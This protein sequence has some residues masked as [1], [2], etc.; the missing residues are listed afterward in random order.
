MEDI[1]KKVAELN[2]AVNKLI[3]DVQ[4]EHTAMEKNLVSKSSF[5]EYS[6]NAKRSLEEIYDKLAK[7]Q[8]PVVN[9]IEEDK[10]D[11]ETKQQVFAEWL[12]KGVLGPEERKV[13][14]IAD[15]THAGVLA[16]YEYVNEIIRKATLFSPLR[17]IANIRQT[18][19]YAVELPSETGIGVATWVAESGEKT[20]TTGLEYALTEINTFEMKILYKATQKMLEDSR[21][22]IESEI[23]QASG[24]GFGLL[25]GTAFYSG[26][27]TTSPEGIVVNATVLADARNVATDNTLVF[28]D[29]IG[30]S[31]QLASPYIPNAAWLLNRGT[32]GTIITFKSAAT[33]VYLLQPNLQAGQPTLMLGSPIYEWAD[34]PNT[35]ATNIPDGQIIALYGDFR[36][37]YTIADRVDIVIQRLIEKYAE[38]GMIGFLGRKRIGGKVVLPE[39]IQILKN[40]TS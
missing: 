10:K 34:V 15:T 31:Y 35:P 11:R 17:R 28:D 24:R 37:G 2:G 8:A 14:T 12:R 19:A 40:I 9:A 6:A 4:T 38:F 16:P 23:A 36:A 13:L 3:A 27:G 1:E 7:L 30:T 5:D 33:P 21:F 39:A 32:V 20:E 18:S 29:F 22:S 25:E 26:N